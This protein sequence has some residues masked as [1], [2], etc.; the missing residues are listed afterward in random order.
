MCCVSACVLCECMCA[1]VSACV[2]VGVHVCWCECM[3]C[4]SACVLCECMCAV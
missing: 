2:L 1:G 3:C 4:V